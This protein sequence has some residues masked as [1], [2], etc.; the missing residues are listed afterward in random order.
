MPSRVLPTIDTHLTNIENS[1]NKR[2]NYIEQNI[3]ENSKIVK[4]DV[5]QVYIGWKKFAFKDD[6]T[7]VAIGMIIATSFKNVVKSLIIDILM[8]CLIG[9]GV[10]SNTEDLFI[11][12]KRGQSNITYI[13]LKQAKEDGAVTVNYG[14]FLHV[15]IDLLFVSFVL[16]MLMKV[17]TKV[18]KEIKEEL[19]KIENV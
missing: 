18:K 11:I 1:I 19:K 3:E 4:K 5:K 9:I 13:T 14:L 7:N 6:I 17:T 10:G 12:L 15:F 8:P 2:V 16:Y